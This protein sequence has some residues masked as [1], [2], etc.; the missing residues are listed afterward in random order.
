MKDTPFSFSSDSNI[1]TTKAFN[2]DLSFT[3]YV[4]FVRSDSYL[5]HTA[6][7]QTPINAASLQ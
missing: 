7:A 6:S 1:D 3:T 2:A 5:V 4:Y